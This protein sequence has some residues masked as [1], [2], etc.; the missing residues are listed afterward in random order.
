MRKARA[1]TAEP[2]VAILVTAGW[3]I[4][5]EGPVRRDL[6]EYGYSLDEVGT[7]S[8]LSW[9]DFIAFVSYP[10]EGSAIYR[11]QFADTDHPEDAEWTATPMLLAEVVDQ[12]AALY[13]A[14]TNQPVSKFP[15]PVPRPGRRPEKAFASDRVEI[16]DLNAVLGIPDL[17]A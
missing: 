2:L 10:S 11:A 15:D 3:A 14:Q 8:G 4:E 12:L 17:L 5:H 13:W 6:V 16:E 7:S 9:K 1:L